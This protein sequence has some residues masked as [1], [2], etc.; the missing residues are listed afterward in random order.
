MGSCTQWVGGCPAPHRVV[1]L[2]PAVRGAC[3]TASGRMG[4]PV[5]LRH[6][7]RGH[8]RSPDHRPH[9]GY[10]ALVGGGGPTNRGEAASSMELAYGVESVWYQ[11][12]A[13]TPAGTLAGHGDVDG[14]IRDRIRRTPDPEDTVSAETRCSCAA[15]HTLHGATR[16]RQ[17][18]EHSGQRPRGSGAW[19]ASRVRHPWVKRGSSVRARD[20]SDPLSALLVSSS[21]ISSRSHTACRRILPRAWS[22]SPPSCHVPVMSAARGSASH[23]HQRYKRVGP[24]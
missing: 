15:R 19:V 11:R 12:A 4:W 9:G 6:L 2:P 20:S 5:I 21:S 22:T 14:R 23:C 13:P 16:G 17:R 18:L 1:A 7:G 24:V 8:G 3:S 10:S